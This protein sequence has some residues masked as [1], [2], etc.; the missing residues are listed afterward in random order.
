MDLLVAARLPL[1]GAK[2]TP[3]RRALLLE[4]SWCEPTD[5]AR[6]Q[7]LD[8]VIDGRFAW[9]DVAAATLAEE[10][11]G[12]IPEAGSAR[13]DPFSGAYLNALALRYYLVKLLRPVAYFTQVRPLTAG[14]RVNLIAGAHDED[15]VAV[16][17]QISRAAGARLQVRRVA[18][19]HASA[20]AFPVDAWWRGLLGRIA[21]LFEPLPAGDARP[22]V[23]LCGNPRLLQPACAELR[24]Q[25]CRLWWLFDRFA[26]KPWLRWR[27]AGVGQLVC[28]SSRGRTD[29]LRGELP[30]PLA[31]RGIDLAGP[32]RRWLA[33]RAASCGQ[34]QTRLVE[35]IEQHFCRVRPQALL[36]D[37]DATP[38]ARAAAAAARRHGAVSL[39]VQHGLPG[40]RFGFTPPVADRF[41]AWDEP[42]AEQLARWGMP[43]ERMACP[44]WGRA[45]RRPTEKDR[46]F[47]PSA[48]RVLLLCTTPP[49]DARPDSIALHLTRRTY[50]DMLRAAFSVVAALPRAE[51]IVKLHPRSGDD[52]LVR[53]LVDEFPELR[54]RLVRRGSVAAW[55]DRVDI[56]LSCGSTAGVEAVAAGLP[57]I[58]LAPPKASGFPPAEPWGLLGTA[59]TA[60]ELR[61]LMARAQTSPWKAVSPFQP[62]PPRWIADEVMRAV[63]GYADRSSSSNENRP[64]SNPRLQTDAERA[65]GRDVPSPACAGRCEEKR[66][67]EPPSPVGMGSRARTAWQDESP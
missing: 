45:R 44:S 25:G 40:C 47:L 24:R 37:E 51:L 10:A 41:L 22:R 46:P 49:R 13:P 1:L 39:V 7:A 23:V 67:A 14:D 28:R 48:C 31:C 55:L 8:D 38:T 16:L 34:R 11:A 65:S 12:Q 9:I 4:G 53:S 32:V 20:A 15:Y 35:K 33:A 30:G 63:V 6:H 64:P 54:V 43:P 52:P 5:S 59:T 62:L 57:T 3:G 66:N 60:K 50:A 17:R 42:S 61:R 21:G 19:G 29:R 2:P 27:P 56:V 26:M 58:G 36:L 18:V